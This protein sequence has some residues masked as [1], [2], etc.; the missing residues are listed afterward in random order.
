MGHGRRQKSEFTALQAAE[1]YTQVRSPQTNDGF[2]YVG[3]RFTGAAGVADNSYY[4]S[5]IEPL[6][7]PFS[8][9]VFLNNAMDTHIIPVGWE[10]D[11][12]PATTCAQVPSI[13]FWEYHSTAPILTATLSTLVSGCSARGRSWMRRRRNTAIRPSFSL[14]GYPALLMRR[15][16]RSR[17]VGVQVPLRLAQA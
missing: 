16:P 13:H 15:P 17:L 7:F 12:K 5:R 10:F 11:P 2:V 4:L 8:E 1:W 14:A 6:R 9:V 3:N